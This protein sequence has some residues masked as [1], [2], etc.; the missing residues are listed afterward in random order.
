MGEQ[1]I[2]DKEEAEE[3]E[4]GDV[5]GFGLLTQSDNDILGLG[6]DKS[7]EEITGFSFGTASKKHVRKERSGG[8]AP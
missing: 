3:E 4:F 1:K 8:A 2:E 5:I 7:D 6:S